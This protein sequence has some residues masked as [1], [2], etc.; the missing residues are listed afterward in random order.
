MTKLTRHTANCSLL[1]AALMTLGA[2]TG[3]N[4]AEAAREAPPLVLGPN[5][6]AVARLADIGSAVVI[7]GPLEP[8]QV[9]NVRAQ[10]P[11]TV[12]GLRVDR[13]TSVRAGQVMA[14]I[15]AAGIRSQAAGT[16]AA[17][18]AARANLAVSEQRLVAA[19]TLRQAGAMSEIDY[20]TAVA[21]HEAAQAQLAAAEAQAATAGEAAARTAITAPITGVVSQRFVQG[22]EAVNPGT[23]LFTVVNSSTL[24]LAGQAGVAVAARVQRGQPVVFTLDAYPGR[25][26]RGRVAR[27]DPTADP[28][29]RQVGVY[30]QLANSG[31]QIV[32]GQ[33]A[34]GRIVTRS[35][36]QVVVP[37]TAIRDAGTSPSVLIVKDNRVQRRPV[38]LGDRDERSGLI[39]VLSGV[40]SGETVVVVPSADLHEG[41]SV[42][43]AA[44]SGRA[45]HNPAQRRP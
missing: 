11:G 35:S 38:T 6:L 25:E 7:S 3:S 42:I 30:V 17:V 22:G 14:V 5:D 33:F 41:S 24:E 19:R 39:A 21:G 20:R 34:S 10:A 29:T 37:E 43:V 28:G 45:A 23:P 18:A 13:G 16:R 44:D 32:G 31:G 9:V 8:A 12:T 2:C 40:Q 15:E 36:Q 1:V 26:F 4:G 27:I